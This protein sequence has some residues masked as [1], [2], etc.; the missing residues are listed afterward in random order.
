MTLKD[1]MHQLIEIVE[2]NPE[3][4]E[5]E[6][7]AATDDEGNQFNPVYYSP[8]LGNFVNGT[9][10]VEEDNTPPNAICLN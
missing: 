6:V 3:A 7:L 9:F 5:C 10:F 4:L 1:Y 2:A 8:C